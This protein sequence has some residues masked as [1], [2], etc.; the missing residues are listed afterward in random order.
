VGVGIIR[1]GAATIEHQTMDLG[2]P[3]IIFADAN[4]D[5]AA[6]FPF[7]PLGLTAVGPDP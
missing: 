1:N 2:G 7:R 6:L 3:N 5:A 4:M